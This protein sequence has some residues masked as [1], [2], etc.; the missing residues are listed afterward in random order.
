VINLNQLDVLFLG[1]QG[2][3][4]LWF[5]HIELAII[6][7]NPYKHDSLLYISDLKLQTRMTKTAG[8][9]LSR[10]QRFI[11]SLYKMLQACKSIPTPHGK[12]QIRRHQSTLE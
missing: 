6:V 12:H 9:Q 2:I 11:F 8:Q 1:Q 10:Q 4:H 3:Q 7:H 5:N